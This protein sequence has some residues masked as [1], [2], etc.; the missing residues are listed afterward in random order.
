VT[1]GESQSKPGAQVDWLN[2]TF[3]APPCGLDG[4]VGHL[5]QLLGRPVSGIE[6]GGRLGFESRI[7]LEARVGSR[8]VIIGSVA[9][10]GE[11]QRGR[12]MLQLT[13]TG[14]QFVPDWHRL[15]DL[16]EQLDARITRL[17]LAVDLL[18]GE[19]TVDEAVSWH[20]EGGYTSRG[21]TPSTHVAG[22]WVDGVK[23]RTFYVGQAANGKLLRVYEKGKE[24][25]DL[26][27][28]WVR[29][30]VQF[31]NRDR[32]IPF[33]ALT[34]R[35][36]FFAGAYPALVEVVKSAAVP[37]ATVQT[38]GHVTLSHLLHHLR[39]CYGKCIDVLTSD[40]GASSSALVEEVRVY[41]FP[42]R[43]NPSSVEAGVTWADV[44]AR[45]K[46]RS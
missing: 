1:R 38:G 37:I 18:D 26:L 7:D 4:F 2:A 40:A 28:P 13:G 5:A 41:G 43:L 33:E 3:D 6:A 23:G 36:Q 42:R 31:G 29:F 11:S 21:R 8:A 16:L 25:G 22:D 9:Y 32:V 45:M 19:H 15:R 27:S 35:D 14:C 10:G 20:G 30:E 34:E 24:Q 12:W 39:R 46:D 44:L 17:D